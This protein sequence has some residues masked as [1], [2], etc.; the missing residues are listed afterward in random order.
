MIFF[1]GVDPW[2]TKSVLFTSWIMGGKTPNKKLVFALPRKTTGVVYGEKQGGL[3]LPVIPGTDTILHLAIIRLI[4]ENG[5]E[6]QGMDRAK[7]G[8]QVG[9]QR[10]AWDAAPATRR[11]SGSRLGVNTGPTSTAT[12]SG[13]YAIPT[14]SWSGPPRLRVCPR[15]PFARR[16]NSWPSPNPDGTRQKD[17]VHAREGKLLVQQFREHGFLRGP[18]AGLRSR[19]AT[20]PCD[21]PRRGAS[22]GL[23]GCRRLSEGHV[24]GKGAGTP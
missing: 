13:F 19:V 22:A 1:S 24:S 16:L 6:R 21:F 7:A 14:P 12:R 10:P 8:E 3:F 20:G 4:L 2:E 17:L 9:D 5:W 23:D 15:R 18:R 11:G